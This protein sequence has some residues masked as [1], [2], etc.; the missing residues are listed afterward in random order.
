M[1]IT[2][3]VELPESLPEAQQQGRLVAFASA[4]VSAGT[5][6]PSA[7]VLLARQIAREPTPNV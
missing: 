7:F 2:G 1:W 6:K 4:V 3:D 5:L